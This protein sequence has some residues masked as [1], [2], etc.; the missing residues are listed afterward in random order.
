MKDGVKWAVFFC[1]RVA[2]KKNSDVGGGCTWSHFVVPILY[3]YILCIYAQ[4]PR[5]LTLK[6]D[7]YSVKKNTLKSEYTL[8]KKG[9]YTM[10]NIYR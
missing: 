10:K 8:I 5:T 6:R 2:D 3:I 9:N 7:N 1:V 4:T